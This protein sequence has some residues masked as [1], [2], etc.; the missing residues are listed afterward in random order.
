MLGGALDEHVAA[1]GPEEARLRT[2]TRDANSAA[3]DPPHPGS[4]P[5]SGAENNR[6]RFTRATACIVL[7]V[8]LVGSIIAISSTGPADAPAATAGTTTTPPTDEASTPTILLPQPQ[9]LDATVIPA[10]I[11]RPRPDLFPIMAIPD[12]VDVFGDYSAEV[13]DLSRVT[14]LVGRIDGNRLTSG[15]QIQT[16]PQAPPE[17]LRGNRAVE[18][19]DGTEVGVGELRIDESVLPDGYEVLVEPALEPPRAL[20]AATAVN[21]AHSD[22]PCARVQ[23]HDPLPPLA[24]GGELERVEINGTPAWSSPR[25]GGHTIVWPVS[26]TTWSRSGPAAAPAR[27]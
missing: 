18:M 23:V 8:G 25:P 4:E 13:D 20:S 11:D 3:G 16:L 24:S 12:A 7:M 17:L 19:I 27:R 22:G 26:D 9:L 2:R 6:R 21:L 15:I 14:A 1:V 10:Q 5:T